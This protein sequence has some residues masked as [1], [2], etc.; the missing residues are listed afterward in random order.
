VAALRDARMTGQ[1][2]GRVLYGG[3]RR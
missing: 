1:R 2:P 3:A